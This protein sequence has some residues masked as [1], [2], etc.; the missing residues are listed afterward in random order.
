[1]ALDDYRLLQNR[2][3]IKR[4]LSMIFAFTI[5]IIVCLVIAEKYTE[6]IKRIAVASRK[7][8]MGEL[9]KIKATDRGDEDR[10]PC[11]QL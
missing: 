4:I 5:G 1:M 10:Y 9:V 3:Q 2:N 6:P 7:I 8:A 11:E